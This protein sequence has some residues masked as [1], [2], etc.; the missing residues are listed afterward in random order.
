MRVH[1]EGDNQQT[2]MMA[3]AY[4][5]PKMAVADEYAN[6]PDLPSPILDFDFAATQDITATL[7]VH[8]NEMH[9]RI[10]GRTIA[11]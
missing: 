5:V 10:N 11:H 2:L 8:D 1:E 6:D 9:V 4:A 7:T 3:A